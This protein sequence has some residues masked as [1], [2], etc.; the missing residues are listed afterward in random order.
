MEAFWR[1]GVFSG[2]LLIMLSW[3]R[4]L[5]RC[6]M[7]SG[8]KRWPVNLGLALLN[9]LLLRLSVGAAAW[10]A[11]L[12][13]T[14]QQTGLLHVLPVPQ[15]LQMVLSLVLL[16]LAI[17]AQHVLAHRWRWLWRFHQVHHTDL[18]F[19]TT[20]AVRFHPVEIALSMF[21]KVIVVLMLGAEPSAVVIF[22]MLL[23]G[24]ALFNHGNVGLTA[25]G[26]RWLRYFLVTPD[27]HRIHHSMLRQET[28]S[29][30]GFSLSCWDRLFKTY[31]AQPQT[32]QTTMLIGLPEF[33]D[34]NRLGFLQL[35]VLPFKRRNTD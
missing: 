3:E 30:Y 15:W 4:L 25:G 1:L 32:G 23:S 7:V 13:A 2:V 28:D 14:E 17:Y 22:E 29:N 9:V 35:L 20:T 19:D 8:Y 5:P 12:W 6:R 26:E 24:C 18:E 34:A 21:Y 16:D 33:R 11:A 31:R 10:Q 27:M